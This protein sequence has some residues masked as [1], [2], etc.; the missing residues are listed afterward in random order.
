MPYPAREASVLKWHGVGEGESEL[1]EDV[2]SFLVLENSW[3][4]M[5]HLWFCCFI[6]GTLMSTLSKI[7]S[8]FC[9]IFCTRHLFLSIRHCSLSICHS[10]RTKI[11]VLS[12]RG[13][14]PVFAWN[15]SPR[16]P[17]CPN[18]KPPLNGSKKDD[19]C[20]IRRCAPAIWLSDGLGFG[21]REN[22]Q[23]NLS[24]YHQG[25]RF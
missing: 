8:S 24:S 7:Q 21:N 18:T 25:T 10:P 15:I 3:S 19:T 23:G 14:D 6:F 1:G 9:R 13:M 2:T 17:P 20:R 5:T 16:S 11:P 12:S 22:I 4:I